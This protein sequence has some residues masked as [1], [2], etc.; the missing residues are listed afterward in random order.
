MP[1]TFFL[2]LYCTVGT[3]EGTK[4]GDYAITIESPEDHVSG[5]FLLLVEL[6]SAAACAA[7]FIATIT[8]RNHHRGMQ[9]W[10]SKL[11]WPFPKERQTNNWNNPSVDERKKEVDKS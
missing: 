5:G 8:C 11:D 4:A 9:Q 7:C 1:E 3:E 2:L 6:P 10:S